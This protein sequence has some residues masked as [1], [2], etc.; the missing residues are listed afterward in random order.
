MTIFSEGS[1]PTNSSPRSSK[2]PK[3]RLHARTASWISPWSSDCGENQSQGAPLKTYDPFPHQ[4]SSPNAFHHRL[5]AGQ[6]GEDLT[7]AQDRPALGQSS[8]QSPGR[9]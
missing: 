2:A 7:H 5:G 9:L 8:Q 1:W 4:D 3:R 6:G